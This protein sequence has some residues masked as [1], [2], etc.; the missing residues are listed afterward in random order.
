MHHLSAAIARK[1]PSPVR[2]NADGLLLSSTTPRRTTVTSFVV[3]ARPMF[4]S[5]KSFHQLSHQPGLGQAG[6]HRPIADATASPKAGGVEASQ[7]RWEKETWKQ[8]R[9]APGLILGS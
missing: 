6:V 4:E 7:H 8:Q 3:L 2:K 5:P 1:K 9:P